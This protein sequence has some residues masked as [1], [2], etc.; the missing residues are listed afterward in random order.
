MYKK[1][2]YIFTFLTTTL[3]HIQ[4]VTADFLI[5][6]GS[7]TEDAWVI[8]S[9]R[10]DAGNGW[11]AGF[12][13]QGW[14]K[15]EPGGY[16][17][18]SVPA[19]NS[20]VYI[21]VEDPYGNEIEPL[22][23]V[24]RSSYH[25]WMHPIEKFTVVETASGEFLDSNLNQASLTTA[26]LYEFNTD[27]VI[28]I[29]TKRNECET[30]N[31]AD[32]SA[33]QI[34]N[35][36]IKSVLWID[37][38]SGSGSGV[39]IDQERQLA[40]TNHH[41]TENNTWVN[42]Y[43]PERDEDGRLVRDMEYYRNNYRSLERVGYATRGRVI[44]KD[45]VN[46]VAIIQLNQLSP[47]AQEIDHDFSMQVETSM[48][49]GD[50]VH[51]LGNPGNRLWNWTQGSFLGVYEDCLL[52]GGA[53]LEM[54][55]DAE[56]GNSG[57]PILNGQGVLIGILAEGTDETSAFAVP[58]KNIK[59]L[60]DTLR[61]E[62]KIRNTTGRA[63]SYQMRWT[64]NDSWQ[65]YR[66]E[67]GYVRTHSSSEE[68]LAQGFPQIRFDYI[69]RDD[70]DTYKYYRLGATLRFKDDNEDLPTYYFNYDWRGDRLNL[71]IDNA[72]APLISSNVVPKKNALLPNYPNPFNPE[73]WIP[74]QLAESA[75]V[76]ISIYSADGKT[77]RTLQLGSIPAGN[78]KSR[79]RAAY[80]DGKNA[81]GETVATG[82]YF[83]TLTASD[84][85]ATR[86]MLILK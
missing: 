80:W 26:T 76:S 67:T 27:E 73:T 45:A 60:L 31:P 12:R 17:N 47:I 34:Y 54:E 1:L 77:V 16:R 44:A 30:V 8:Y 57:G 75:D 14:Y 22:D 59:A 62:L 58:L 28:H 78:Y 38:D 83:Y 33:Q 25:F 50:K 71:Y 61:W 29:I 4:L 42:V 7:A 64:Q 66:L 85:S 79:S 86:K 35:R 36:S 19:D 84:F 6:N 65:N 15:I 55:G 52:K 18:L 40:V 13:T 74:Y 81:F 23:N 24:A 3:I 41:V 2:F 43:F 9:T 48:Q 49:R 72:A 37:T 68:N 10:R 39:I 82:V 5:A 56:V 63:V 21:R 51:I 70:D 69:L 11:P 46:D 53:C 20:Y 32:L